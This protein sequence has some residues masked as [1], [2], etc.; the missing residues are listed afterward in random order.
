[1]KKETPILQIF[2]APKKTSEL[3]FDVR[4]KIEKIRRESNWIELPWFDSNQFFS[5]SGEG[6]P[7]F[8]EKAKEKKLT[9]MRKSGKK[10]KFFGWGFC[11]TPNEMKKS[12]EKT[13]DEM[14][15]KE[16]LRSFK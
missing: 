7:L 11:G 9:L 8:L 15:R 16:K 12:L 4:E 2:E 3:F 13:L 14:E 5:F 10:T 1:M 6:L